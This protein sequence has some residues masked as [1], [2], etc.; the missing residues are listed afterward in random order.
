MSK[1]R[2][3]Q[4][5]H[6][7]T[8][9][10]QKDPIRSIQEAV[11]YHKVELEEATPEDSITARRASDAKKGQI[12]EKE[13]RGEELGRRRRRLEYPREFNS[14]EQQSEEHSQQQAKRSYPTAGENQKNR[15]SSANCRPRRMKRI[16]SGRKK[17][18]QLREQ[19]F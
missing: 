6:R 13:H 10:M 12:A 19:G 4:A 3:I 7:E 11:N 1:A 9:C 8:D 5:R 18:D 14:A 17:K 16:M 2:R 15:K